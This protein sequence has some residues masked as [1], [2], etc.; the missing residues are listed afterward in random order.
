[1]A[2]TKKELIDRIAERTGEKQVS[3]KTV[4]Q[5]FFKETIEELAKGNRLEF[6]D[7]GIFE[8]HKR[9]ARVGQNPRTMEK[10]QIPAKRV[11]KFRVGH[12]MKEKL[13]GKAKEQ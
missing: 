6:R 11:A 9:K 4:I 5:H 2:T 1:M 12:A 8:S 7:F 3:V 13:N 10:V